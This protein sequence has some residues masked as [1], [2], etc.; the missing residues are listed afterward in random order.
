LKVKRLKQVGSC[1]PSQNSERQLFLSNATLVLD[2][3]KQSGTVLATGS[4]LIEQRPS[5][6]LNRH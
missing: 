5:C 2:A 1:R 3:D 6:A 4:E